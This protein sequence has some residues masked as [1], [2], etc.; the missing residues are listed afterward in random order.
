MKQSI[1]YALLVGSVAC[2]ASLLINHTD[3]APDN[4]RVNTPRKLTHSA[5]RAAVRPAA[6]PEETPLVASDPA[7]PPALAPLEV[8]ATIPAARALAT[9]EERASFGAPARQDGVQDSVQTP[10][11]YDEMVQRARQVEYEADLQVA[12]LDNC[13]GLTGDQYRQAFM[14]YARAS[15]SYDPSIPIE[16]QVTAAFT[17]SA[18]ESSSTTA[19]GKTAATATFESKST[20]TQ[21]VETLNDDQQAAFGQEWLNRDLWWTEIVSQLAADFPEQ[22]ATAA[23]TPADHQGENIFDILNSVQ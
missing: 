8:V 5:T 22:K 10:L 17:P 1:A 6:R 9:A 18:S 19:G 7:S 14:V 2:A 15:S 21:I 11:T 20:E 4:E 16:G 13:V 3:S 23:D 12:R